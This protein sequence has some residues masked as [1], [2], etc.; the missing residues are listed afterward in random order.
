MISALRASVYDLPLGMRIAFVSGY[1]LLPPSG[2]IFLSSAVVNF[3]LMLLNVGKMRSF[4]AEIRD[5]KLDFNWI[6][7]FAD[8]PP[9]GLRDDDELGVIHRHWFRFVKPKNTR[10]PR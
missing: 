1:P 3:N 7:D 9:I 4:F 10:K 2:Q 6:F 5:A 8:R